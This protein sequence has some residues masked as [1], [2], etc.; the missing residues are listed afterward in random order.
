MFFEFLLFTITGAVVFHYTGT[1]YA[2]AP[3]YGS[4]QERFG[5]VAAGFVL[6]TIIIVGILYSL[7]TSRAIF[8]Q[9]FPEGSVHRTRH[10][11]VGWATWFV[12]V[13]IG[14]VISFIIGEAVPFFSDLLALISSLFDRLVLVLLQYPVGRSAG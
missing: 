3:G 2:T 7:V 1:A 11:V 5:K 9:I 8:F 4:L 13:F 6:P 14:W 10:T 12:V